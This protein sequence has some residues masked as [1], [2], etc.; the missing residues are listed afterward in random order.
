MRDI[1]IL[2]NHWK[3]RRIFWSLQFAVLI[4]YLPSLESFIPK[5]TKTQLPITFQNVLRST[6]RSYASITRFEEGRDMSHLEGI[7]F[8][9]Y[10][11][12]IDYKIIQSDFNRGSVSRRE[13]VLE[14]HQL[15]SK[16][17][18]L[19]I[20]KESENAVRSVSMLGGLLSVL[21]T[22]DIWYAASS[23]LIVNIFATQ[24]NE[25]GT[26]FRILGAKMDVLCR[27]ASKVGRLLNSFCFSRG[28]DESLKET[29]PRSGEYSKSLN[30][31][32]SSRTNNNRK[33]DSLLSKTSVRDSVAERIDQ[34]VATRRTEYSDYPEYSSND[35]IRTEDDSD[36]FDPIPIPDSI[37]PISKII[38]PP[39]YS[40]AD[41]DPSSA[42]TSTVFDSDASRHN[43]RKS[44]IT[45]QN[46][47][48]DTNS[49]RDKNPTIDKNTSSSW[50]KTSA[51]N[52]KR[53]LGTLININVNTNT[54]TNIKIRAPPTSP[55]S[56]Y[57]QSTTS[58][59]SSVTT[60]TSSSTP[61]STS[62]PTVGGVS[63]AV[64]TC[65]YS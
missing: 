56:A 4:A 25:L 13:G 48:N 2:F 62:T 9:L 45:P 31:P 39:N 64:S 37:P 7:E 55:K 17:L 47:M 63:E 53:P 59:P 15:D 40:Y 24:S 1:S 14:S 57:K 28:I 46:V 12:S 10:S 33:R 38:F 21:V 20:M 44:E 36:E 19:M 30:R 16:T 49:A 27:E 52:T 29:T 43:D 51:V 18:Q 11:D 42:D 22:R 41:D 32:S 8:D 58:V 35:V 23:F 61:T 3:M 65:Y 6:H 60:S 5:P 26:A 50:N 34:K 54:N